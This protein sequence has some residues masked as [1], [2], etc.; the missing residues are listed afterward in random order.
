ML[1]N[2]AA[3]RRVLFFGGKGGVG[4][5]TLAATVALHEAERG[6]RVHLVST[7]PAHNL[8]HLFGTTLADDGTAVTSRL[9]ATEIDPAATTER[10]LAAV[11]G[12]M[13]R[14]MPEH[15]HGEVRAYL[16][17]ARTAPGM[18]EA[19]IL[20]RIAELAADEDARYD[21]IVFDT[22]PSGHTAR[23]MTLPETMGMWTESL[24]RRQDRAR[25]FGEA[26]AALDDEASDILGTRRPGGAPRGFGSSGGVSDRARRRERDHEIRHILLRRRERFDRL[27]TI[28]TA[29]GETAFALVLA[30]ERLPVAET[31]EFHAELSAHGI[32]VEALIVNKR[33]PADAG[34]LLA[35]RRRHEEDHLADLVCAI[36]DVPVTEVPLLADDVVGLA[37]LAGFA[38]MLGQ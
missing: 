18:H 19:A 15:L 26:M 8:G 12:T 25:G 5:T 38:R 30:A 23:L 17:G 35:S 33:A 34:G 2:L 28:L 24:L 20:E 32:P 6:R 9:I 21:L 14:L 1:L 37:A 27:R 11:E 22:A 10:H 36:P 7:D 3:Q 31:I 4:K 16:R 13:R 29:E